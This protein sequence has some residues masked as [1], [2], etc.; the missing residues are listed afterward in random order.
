MTYKFP[1]FIEPIVNPV[2]SNIYVYF[3]I[4]GTDMTVIVNLT[5]DYNVYAVTFNCSEAFVDA[6]STTQWVNNKLED[7]III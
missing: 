5:V 4:Q 6:D 2:I 1:E 7:Y 3:N